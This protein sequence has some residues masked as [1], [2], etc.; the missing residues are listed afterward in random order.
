MNIICE[1]CQKIFK[2]KSGRAAHVRYSKTCGSQYSSTPTNN[3]IKSASNTPILQS[4]TTQVS[5][6][7]NLESSI[8]SPNNPPQNEPS[9]IEPEVIKSPTLAE[10]STNW[11]DDWE[12]KTV[13]NTKN[14]LPSN[15]QTNNN[16]L[17][18][19]QMQPQQAFTLSAEQYSAFYYMLNDFLD[20]LTSFAG[21]NEV[22]SLMKAPTV[23]NL[24]VQ[25]K[26]Y[27]DT[28]QFQ[29]SPA[30]MLMISIALAYSPAT[31][32]SLRSIRQ[33]RKAIKE[34]NGMSAK[35]REEL[36]KN[37]KID[38]LNKTGQKK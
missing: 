11:L 38:E 10:F 26:A 6:S 32:K 2:T 21:G 27:A 19:N 9:K 25:T 33:N 23:K 5:Q 7:Q 36:Q 37:I 31:T 18:N 13:P 3:A 14:K 8:P 22:F 34:L 12:K 15:Q 24:G 1:K 29:I 17:V 16:Q 20:T 28:L 30:K 35:E 4:S